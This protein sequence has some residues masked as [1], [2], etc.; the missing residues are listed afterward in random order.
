MTALSSKN[1]QINNAQTLIGTLEHC[2]GGLLQQ[3]SHYPGVSLKYP[4]GVSVSVSK[5]VI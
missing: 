1:K 5:I 2:C 4:T 3:S